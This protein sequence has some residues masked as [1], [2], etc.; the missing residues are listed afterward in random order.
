MT[1]TVYYVSVLIGRITGVARPSVCLLSCL[2][3]T[4][5]NS[6]TKKNVQNQNCCE[7]P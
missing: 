2:S 5:V 1:N 6:K 7:L 4:A 3:S